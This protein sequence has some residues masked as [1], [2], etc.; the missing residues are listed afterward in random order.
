[1]ATCEYVMF[2]QTPYSEAEYCIEEAEPGSEYC[3]DHDPELGA[4][5]WDDVRKDL[6]VGRY[7]CY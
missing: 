1:M 7:D 4:P 6:L 3:S 2:H 5:D